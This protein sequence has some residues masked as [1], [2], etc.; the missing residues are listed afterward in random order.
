MPGSEHGDDELAGAAGQLCNMSLEEL[1]EDGVKGAALCDVCRL[2]AARHART[3]PLAGAVS[4][5]SRS[6]TGARAPDIGH[7]IRLVSVLPKWSRH[8]VC[9]VF[10]QKVA[11]RLLPSG[12]PDAHWYKV[13]PYLMDNDDAAAEWVSINIVARELSWV[14]TKT[15]FTAQFQLSDH[16]ETLRREYRECKQGKTEPVQA[17][18]NRFLVLVHQLGY[19]PDNEH[20]VS[21]FTEH[22]T[23]YIYGK[24]Q[25]YLVLKQMDD[26]EFAIKQ[27]DKIIA[28]CIRLDVAQR[29][30]AV[31]SAAHAVSSGAAA[32]PS[33]SAAAGGKKSGAGGV[34]KH[35]TNHPHATNHTTAE[36][37][38]GK[39]VSRAV[40][41]ASGGGHSAARDGSWR[42]SDK[43]PLTCFTCGA[44]G[45][46][47]PECPKKE[48]GQTQAGAAARAAAGIEP[49]RSGREPAPR[50]FLT[51]MVNSATG[52]SVNANVN[53]STRAVAVKSQS[54]DSGAGLAG[55]SVPAVRA[56]AVLDRTL[57]S[58]VV[59]PTGRHDVL[60]LFQ[61]RVFI[62]LIDTGADTSC[63]DAALAAELQLPVQALPG[64]VK[65][66]HAGVT[67]DRIGKTAALGI[68]AIFPVPELRLPSKQFSLAFEVLPLDTDQYQFIIGADLV[69]V[70]FPHALPSCFYPAPADHAAA[71]I[72]HRAAVT[73]A[74]G[75]LPKFGNQGDFGYL[76]K[77]GNQPTQTVRAMD[78]TIDPLSGDGSLP[79]NELPVRLELAVAPALDADYAAKR[80]QV[81]ADPDIVQ[82]LAVNAGIAGFCNLPESVVVL[83]VDPAMKHKLFRK[84]YPIAQALRP[85]VSEVVLRWLRAGKIKRAPVGCQYNNPLTVAPKRDDQGTMTGIRVCLD[86]RVLNEALLSHDRF[87]LPYI[88]EAL[89]QLAGCTLFGELDLEEAYL[90]FLMHPDSQQYT[91]FTWE[92]VQYVFVGAPFG[93]ATLPSHFQRIMSGAFADLP[94]TF[95]YLDNLP[96]GSSDWGSHRDQALTLIERCNQLNLKIKPSS[97]KIGFSQLRCLGHQLSAAGISIEPGKLKELEAWSQ[98]KTGEHLQSFLG[99]VTFLRQHIRHFADLTAP[100]E[101]IKLQKE[102]V[103]D[104]LLVHH[105]ELTKQALARAPFL[106]FPDFSRPFHIATD[107]SNTGVGGVLYQPD[108][109]DG[110]ITAT[111]IVAICSKKLSQCQRNYSAYKKE[112]YG[113]VYCFRQ[114]HTFVWGRKDVVLWTD[115][116]PLTFMFQSAVLSPALQQ[117][118]DVVLDYQFDIRHRA[119][120]LNVLPDTLSRMYASQYESG[121]WGVPSGIRF[122][123]ADGKELKPVADLSVAVRA[124]GASS[125]VAAD[126]ESGLSASDLAGEGDASAGSDSDS[127]NDTATALSP[128][129]LAVELE[130]RGKTCPSSEHEKQALIEKQHA[131]GHF[132]REA[133]YKALLNAGHWW[134]NLRDQIQ[135]VISSCDPCTRFTVTKAGFNPASFITAAGPW[136]HIQMDC[137]VHLPASKDGYTALLVIID[138]FTGFVV[139]RPLKTTSA[140]LVAHEL[141]QL[142]CTFGLPKILQS[143]NG[144][145]FV[146]D[147]LRSLVQLTGIE[148]RFISPY[149][150]RADGKVERSIGTVMGIIKKLL[151]GSDSDWPLFVPFAQLSF[152][153]KVSTLTGSSPFCL[154]FGRAPNELKSYTDVPADS[155]PVPVSLDAWK[156]HQEK[157]LSVIYPA[158]AQRVAASK[159]KMV[160]SLN[161]QR[162]QLKQGAMPNGAIV[163]LVDKTR[164]NKFQPKYVGPYTVIRRARNG[165]YVLRDA[166]GAMLDRH[167]PPDQLKLVSRKARPSDLADNV[168]EVQSILGHR[169]PPGHIEY[170]VKWKDHNDR[171]WEPASAFHDTLVIKNYWREQRAD[172]D[173]AAAKASAAAT[174]AA[175]GVAAAAAAARDGRG[176]LPISQ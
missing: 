135:S 29:T 31:H 72:L 3:Q 166:T 164:Q 163:M 115:H 100:L 127:D 83:D 78:A 6:S 25:E 18:A 147:V 20:V 66:A 68:T 128:A 21:H 153:Y 122:V 43:K 104:E 37:V 107:A 140:E 24:Y 73:C 22:L 88:R 76:P 71:P 50:Q 141:W 63:I 23:A 118:L 149:N 17:Y 92:G 119:G 145:E 105:F 158:I 48:A 67:A 106:R 130:K 1:R 81:M 70:L 42:S 112:L 8:A 161:K 56:S 10:L 170:H 97:V 12:I 64:K 101:A 146:N 74:D 27:L 142:C 87:Q 91:A 38:K 139:L 174:A 169:G 133:I 51:P 120:I 176:T 125:A 155:D 103:W 45:H 150:P 162:R 124:A 84:Q 157:V 138:V 165:A 86:V 82:A 19:E 16:T 49:R 168:Y 94:F 113:I 173:S 47:A 129:A 98:P 148:H 39:S 35:C 152:N 28:F 32:A 69:R 109:D 41:A 131:L 121:V 167:V 126:A 117:W 77:F 40:G 26:P 62:T 156:T 172:G 7:L 59:V 111:N 60:F 55:D 154:M 15:A 132:G 90:Q 80:E 52:Q 143:D 144:P 108:G 4:E 160:A 137:C 175:A 53:V 96:F 58:T 136:D 116:K 30:A 57:P 79:A 54:P 9:R 123:G 159:S 33:S 114:F 151:H 110:D 171:T 34:V 2:P 13:L 89:E 102:L 134:P 44:V 46:I 75:W 61:E 5:P 85:R 36:C 11:Q 95:P 93:I 99:F 14:D 65:L